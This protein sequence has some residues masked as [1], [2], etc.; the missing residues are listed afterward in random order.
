M[1]VGKSGRVVIEIDPAFKREFRAALERDGMSMKAW[2]LQEAR[3]YLARG[4]QVELMFNSS[5]SDRRE[6]R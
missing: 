3:R 2:F 6:K 4:R 1:A 5:D